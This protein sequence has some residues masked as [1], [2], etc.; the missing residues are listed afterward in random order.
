MQYGVSPACLPSSKLYDIQKLMPMDGN[1]TSSFVTFASTVVRSRQAQGCS[2]V[3][4][5]NI[6]HQEQSIHYQRHPVKIDRVNGPALA[7][8]LLETGPSA[9]GC[10]L[11]R[12]KGT[13]VTPIRAPG[14]LTPVRSAP[15]PRVRS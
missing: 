12:E 9:V 1:E 13:P 8:S 5:S 2:M 10:W 6:V 11:R 4:L 3:S 15:Y 7:G 14:T